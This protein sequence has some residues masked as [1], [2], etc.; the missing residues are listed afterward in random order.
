MNGFKIIKHFFALII[1]LFLVMPTV[2]LSQ[3]SSQPII[4]DVPEDIVEQIFE[5]SFGDIEL[6]E[7]QEAGIKEDI[8]QRNRRPSGE[9]ERRSPAPSVPS[10]PGGT[11]PPEAVSCF[12][13][14]DFGSVEVPLTPSVRTASPGSRVVFTG[15]IKNTNPYP[16]VDGALYIKIFKEDTSTVAGNTSEV[17]DQFFVK[18]DMSLV[19]SSSQDISFEWEVPTYA[20]T[21]TY[22]LGT[23]FVTSKKF[24]LLGL[25]F[26]DD[27]IGNSTAFG[28]AGDVD[29]GVEFDKQQTL[30]NGQ[31]YHFAAFPPKVEKE[32]PVEVSLRIDNDTNQEKQV[33]VSWEL[34]KWD[35]LDPTN[36]ISEKRQ[37][38]KV[39]SGGDSVTYRVTDSS[40]SVYYL[41]A[42]LEYKDTKSII[43]TRFVRRGVNEARI[44]FPSLTA[45]PLQK[46]NEATVFA[47]LHNTGQADIVDNIRFTMSLVDRDSGEEVHSYAYEGYVTNSMM[48]LKDDFKADRNIN[49]LLLIANIY[50]DGV[51]V[52]SAEVEYRCG[53]IDSAMCSEKSGRQSFAWYIGIWIASIF[54]IVVF[55]WLF[56]RYLGRKQNDGQI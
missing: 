27:V 31:Q 17:V 39:P 21:G 28:V 41:V 1:A 52:D 14:Y 8:R 32:E 35:A 46:G 56:I 45:F 6:S 43:A 20:R 12:D 30:L 11:P 40:H 55:G 22:R 3:D 7:E 18:E 16:I 50:Q 34:Y 51:K 9:N 54:A 5:R 23:Y 44:N 33:Q 36:L 53:D 13:Y 37:T 42:T 48:A 47:C 25:S 26:T 49:N 38:V 10:A 15:V 2:G 24:N 19:A 29:E 4:D